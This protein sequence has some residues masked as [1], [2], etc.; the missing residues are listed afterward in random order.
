M[1][2]RILGIASPSSTTVD[3]ASIQKTNTK[4]VNDARKQLEKHEEIPHVKNILE[5]NDFFTSRLPYAKTSSKVHFWNYW[6]T[7]EKL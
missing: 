3:S 5:L 1:K 7:S 2:T 4:R 6:K